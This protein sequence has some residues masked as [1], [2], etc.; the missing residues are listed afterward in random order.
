M[1]V[2][3]DVVWCGVVR[4][5]A[6]RCGAVPCRVVWCG[7]VHHTTREVILSIDSLTLTVGLALAL[8]AYYSLIALL[9][10]YTREVIL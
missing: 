6:V 2:W 4:C 9:T 10:D 5:G 1:V 3:C 7:G 8:T